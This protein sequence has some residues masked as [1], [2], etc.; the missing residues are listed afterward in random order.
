MRLNALKMARHFSNTDTELGAN[1]FFKPSLAL[2]RKITK[3][4][5]KVNN[6]AN[7]FF[8]SDHVQ[9]FPGLSHK[10]FKSYDILM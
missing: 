1:F 9:N 4:P 10:P 2:Q 5:E 8:H 6:A 3:T 7:Q